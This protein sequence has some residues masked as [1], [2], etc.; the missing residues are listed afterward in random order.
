MITLLLWLYQIPY[1]HKLI[2]CKSY[3]EVVVIVDGLQITHYFE[4]SNIIS[5]KKK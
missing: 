5:L 3:M 2:K 4:Q 1:D